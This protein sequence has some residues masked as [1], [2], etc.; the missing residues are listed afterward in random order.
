MTKT[1][2]YLAGF[3][4]R[5]RAIQADGL[6]SGEGKRQKLQAVDLAKSA[7]RETALAELRRSWR[8]LRSNF[9]RLTRQRQ[10]LETA[11]ASKWDF[12]R[13]NYESEAFRARVMAALDIQ[14]VIK[15][16][17]Q[18]VASGDRHRQ[19]VAAEIGAAVVSEKFSNSDLSARDLARRMRADLDRLNST[20]EL[21]KV[22][23]E[24]DAVIRQAVDL[25]QETNMVASVYQDR[26]F[27]ALLRDV[28]ID[29]EFN[30]ADLENFEKITLTFVD[31]LGEVALQALQAGKAL[32][33]SRDFVF[34]GKKY[35]PGDSFTA[36]V[37]LE[38]PTKARE[39]AD[40]GFV[41]VTG[42]NGSG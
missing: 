27:L 24:F 16:Y 19:R 18:A 42:D 10:E 4:Q 17:D 40:Y 41:E 32:K 2:D 25:V 13:L 9:E 12:H 37:G 8:D 11:L 7:Y 29:R 15:L 36:E 39:L 5:R 28:K 20:P 38:Y 22:S 3:E 35:R 30:P 31:D 33:V 1:A 23:L 34:L 6:L 21:L 14:A 26:E